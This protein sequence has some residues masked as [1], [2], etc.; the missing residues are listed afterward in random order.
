M[1][2]HQRLPVNASVSDPALVSLRHRSNVRDASCAAATICFYR[3]F[4]SSSVTLE[5]PLKAFGLFDWANTATLT[6][7]DEDKLG[8]IGAAAMTNMVANQESLRGQLVSQRAGGRKHGAEKYGSASPSA[9][10]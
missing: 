7:P 10:K 5:T 4:K 9:V 3:S 8:A 6:A 2:H 1:H